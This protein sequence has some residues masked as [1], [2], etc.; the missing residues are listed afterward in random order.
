MEGDFLLQDFLCWDE[1]CLTE[2]EGFWMSD[3]PLVQQALATEIADIILAIPKTSSAL[4]F[5]QGFWESIV[6]EWGGID[7]PSRVMLIDYGISCTR[8]QGSEPKR[9][10]PEAEHN[11]I[12][13]PPTWAS[14][15]AHHGL[16][17]YES[18]L[19]KSCVSQVCCRSQIFRGVTI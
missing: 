2:M 11:Q 6:R 19:S 17:E 15:N 7:H 13:G 4:G 1:R 9:Y 5:L 10:N 14:L 3:K 12:T 8:Y 18:F 16:C